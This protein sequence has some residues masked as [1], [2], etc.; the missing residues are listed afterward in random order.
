[1]VCGALGHKQCAELQNVAAKGKGGSSGMG[2]SM[3]LVYR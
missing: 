1:L 2:L 3:K